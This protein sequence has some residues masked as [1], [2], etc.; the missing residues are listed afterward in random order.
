VAYWLTIAG[1]KRDPFTDGDW[2]TR[3]VHWQ[4]QYGPVIM[5]GAHAT[6]RPGDRLI[7][8]A[9]GSPRYFRRAIIFAVQEAVSE[10]RPTKH[11]CWSW[12]LEVRYVIAGPHLESCPSLEQIG[13]TTRSVQ[14]HSHIKLTHDE[15]RTAER[16]IAEAAERHGAL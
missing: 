14:S 15:G 4:G 5:F 10:V 9:S 1:S 11:E 7:K 3:D 2:R 8:Y 12:E 16:L 6:V 13:K